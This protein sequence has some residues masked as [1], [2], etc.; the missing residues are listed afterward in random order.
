MGASQPKYH[1]NYSNENGPHRN[2]R[3]S[4]G[5]ATHNHPDENYPN[6][7]DLVRQTWMGIGK[8]YVAGKYLVH[9]I[10]HNLFEKPRVPYFKLGILAVAMFLVFKEDLRFTLNLKLPSWLIGQSS[11]NADQ[12][13][14]AQFGMAQSIA[15]PTKPGGTETARTSNPQEAQIDAYIKRFRRVAVMEMQQ[16]GVPASIKMAQALL[17]S[18]AGTL[19]DAVVSNNHFGIPL[20]NTPVA[21]AWESWRAHSL[22]L[23]NEHPELFKYGTNFKRW[24]KALE[25]MGYNPMDD[26]AQHL[27]QIIEHYQLDKLDTMGAEQ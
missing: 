3:P 15:L 21:T 27:V 4:A 8:L 9:S 2:G 1:T 6:L 5:I 14:V 16:F 23:R 13:G 20:R 24:A 25:K 26:Y 7:I 11:Q 10:K 17:E 19:N 12:A 18:Q 22:Y